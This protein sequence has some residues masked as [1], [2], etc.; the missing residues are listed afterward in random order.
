MDG[1][2][3]LRVQRYGWDRAAEHYDASWQQ[4]LDVA[5]RAVLARLNIQRGERVL[6]VSCGTGHLAFELGAMVG[7]EGEV[8]GVDL[9]QEMVDAATRQAREREAQHV[10]FARMDAQSL[11]FPDASFDVVLCC[12]GLM[13][14][15]DPERALAEIRRVLRPGGR[16]GLAVWGRR[17][18]CAWAPVFSIIDAEVASEVCPLFFRLGAPGALARAC[19][20]AGLPVSWEE[21]LTHTLRYLDADAACNAMFMAGP[22]AL[23]W[24]RFDAPTRQRVR[25]RYLS[26]IEVWRRNDG[27]ALPAEF[28]AW[29][30][31]EGS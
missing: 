6:D 4:P 30:H 22:V 8:V 10:F 20:D 5:R 18:N 31:G 15:P 1:R 29:A 24:S 16:V 11:R 3:Q 12:F 9:S 27:Y 23:A 7:A 25:D 21:Q 19:G 14:M 13:Y 28:V 26:A 2:L 17:G